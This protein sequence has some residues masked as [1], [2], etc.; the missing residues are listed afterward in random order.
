V[1]EVT[2]GAM[3]AVIDVV[4]VPVPEFKIDPV[5]LTVPEIVTAPVP[6]AESVRL[7]AP[8][9]PPMPNVLAAVCVIVRS[10]LFSDTAA[11]NDAFALF[12][13]V[14][15]PVCPETKE[16]WA[17]TP[18]PAPLSVT[19][20]LMLESPNVMVLVELPAPL[21]EPTESVPR[22]TNTPLV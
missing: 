13:I 8:V 6:A 16:I 19:A 4:P 5:L 22:C 9:I 17:T 20:A 11:A 10:W 18:A 21:A 2:V 15:A 1:I 7:P 12:V 14:A 3:T